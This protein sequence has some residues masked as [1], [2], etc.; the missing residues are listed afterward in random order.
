MDRERQ[1]TTLGVQST[2]DY[3]G[4]ITDS[5]EVPGARPETVRSDKVLV[6]QVLVGEKQKRRESPKESWYVNP[7]GIILTRDHT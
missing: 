6:H 2:L 4:G 3:Y 7:L 5:L 1:V